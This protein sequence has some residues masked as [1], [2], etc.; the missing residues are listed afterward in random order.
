[1]IRVLSEYV[2]SKAFDV[3]VAQIVLVNGYIVSCE[4][5]LACFTYLWMFRSLAFLMLVMSEQTEC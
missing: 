2:F 4:G 5:T 3:S 1:M